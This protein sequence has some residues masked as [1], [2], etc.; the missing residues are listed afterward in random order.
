MYC[1]RTRRMG[2]FVAEIGRYVAEAANV[3]CTGAASPGCDLLA[4]Q[5]IN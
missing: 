1:S 2:R 3:N 4:H 5:A